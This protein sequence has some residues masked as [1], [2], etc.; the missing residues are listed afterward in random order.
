MEHYK[1]HTVT[2]TVTEKLYLH[3]TCD[4]CGEKI[5]EDSYELFKPRIELE[6]GEQYPD[7]GD[8]LKKWVDLCQTCASDL[9][10]MLETT[11]YK[12]NE[13]EIGW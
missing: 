10:K 12:I 4:K 1:E 13:K 8:S 3:T 9:F 6:V 11:G 5:I 2:K 7:S